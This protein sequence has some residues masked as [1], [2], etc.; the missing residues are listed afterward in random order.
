MKFE[1]MTEDHLEDAQA[2]TTSFNWPHTV[3][4]WSFAFEL[5]TGRVLYNEGRLLGTCLTWNLGPDLSTL[6]LLAVARE[7][8]GQ[9]LGRAFLQQ[10][11]EE[12]AG[13]TILLHATHQAIDLY[14]SQS[15]EAIGEVRQHQGVV[16]PATSPATP[17]C[18]PHVHA[19]EAPITSAQAD[20]LLALDHEATG[21]DRS[22]LLSALLPR[23]KIWVTGRQEHPKG[24]ALIRPFG[25]GHVVGP[26]IASGEDD[27]QALINAMLGANT[28]RFVRI[29]ITEEF[30]LSGWLVGLGL[31]EVD[32]VLA[33]SN[34]P[35]PEGS[36]R[37]K[38]FALIGHAFG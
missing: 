27:A 33:M 23:S 3:E 9:G 36:G 32:R 35:V 2:L 1:T 16:L 29:D 15:F 22:T 4:D 31:S 8:Q 26:V 17:M 34:G 13:K 5:G 19:C 38:R 14:G 28:G 20:K 30:N 37:L 10:A 11:I 18:T 24:Y 6:G 21:L 25:R 7:A 12:Q